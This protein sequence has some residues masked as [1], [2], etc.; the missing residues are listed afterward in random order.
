MLFMGMATGEL[1]LAMGVFCIR[2]LAGRT[3]TVC[4][5][6]LLT[7]RVILRASMCVLLFL[8]FLL[9]EMPMANVPNS[10]GTVL[11]GNLML[12]IGLAIC[13]IWLMLG[14]PLLA[15]EVTLAAVAT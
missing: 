3:E 15:F 8:L 1:E 10:L 12:M 5:T 11:M 4:I 13:V 9:K 2:L 7:R 14:V 6:P